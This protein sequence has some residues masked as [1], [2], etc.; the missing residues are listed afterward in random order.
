MCRLASVATLLGVAACSKALR[1][2]WR[3]LWPLGRP[4]LLAALA[5]CWCTRPLWAKTFLASSSH[6]TF[7]V[8]RGCLGLNCTKGTY[9][10]KELKDSHIGAIQPRNL[11]GYPAQKS[12][13]YP[14]QKSVGLSSPE[15]QKN[16]E[17]CGAIQP[18][19]C[20]QKHVVLYSQKRNQKRGYPAQE[21]VCRS[22][23]G[24]PAQKKVQKNVTQHPHN[25]AS[26]CL[27]LLA[28]PSS[29]PMLFHLLSKVLLG[30]QHLLKGFTIFQHLEKLPSSLHILFFVAKLAD[31]KELVASFF[32]DSNCPFL[33]LI[34]RHQKPGLPRPCSWL[35]Q[36]CCWLLQHSCWL[37]HG[38]LGRNCFFHLGFQVSFS[39]WN[40]ASPKAP[41]PSS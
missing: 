32:P 33:L 37:L 26:C 14:A 40:W 1:L 35:L 20:L 2:P 18:K 16:I 3:L 5:P 7:A 8:L 10:T 19:K 34:V 23:W 15:A 38:A 13:G 30:L 25:G 21:K 11:W 36:H 29:F 9:R 41:K 12:V 6:G 31:H 22:M 28:S 17:A 39:R 27:F 24:S 4:R